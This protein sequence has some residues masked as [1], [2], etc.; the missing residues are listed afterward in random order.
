M[1]FIHV[2]CQSVQCCELC[3]FLSEDKIRSVIYGESVGKAVNLVSDRFRNL[4]CG[5]RMRARIV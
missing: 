3:T 1:H 5:W 4:E 2:V